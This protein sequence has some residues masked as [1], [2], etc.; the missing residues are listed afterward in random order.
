M[1]SDSEQS[2]YSDSDD[3]EVRYSNIY[4]FAENDF[5]Y[6]AT[7]LTDFEPEQTDVISNSEVD[8]RKPNIRHRHASRVIICGSCGG[9]ILTQHKSILCFSCECKFHKGCIES[10]CLHIYVIVVRVWTI[11]LVCLYLDMLLSVIFLCN[12]FS[13]MHE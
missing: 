4:L 7:S 6:F 5:R 11:E 3:S 2:S 8:A 12:P 9:A 10:V 1:L 13:N